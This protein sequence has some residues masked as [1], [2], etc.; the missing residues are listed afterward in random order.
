MEA[1]IVGEISPCFSLK[2]TNAGNFVLSAAAHNATV[3]PIFCTPGGYP[4]GS[5]ATDIVCSSWC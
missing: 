3:K 4:Y 2:T 5:F 1:L